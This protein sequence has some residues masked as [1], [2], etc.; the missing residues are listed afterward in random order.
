MLLGHGTLGD[1]PAGKCSAISCGYIGFWTGYSLSYGAHR[2]NPG[3][4]ARGAVPCAG[5]PRP[6]G[7]LWNADGNLLP[8]YLFI[9]SGVLAAGGGFA[10]RFLESIPRAG[11]S[12]DSVHRMVGLFRVYRLS[13]DRGCRGALLYGFC[14]PPG[15]PVHCDG[16]C[17]GL[18]DGIPASGAH[19]G[20]GDD[21]ERCFVL[22]GGSVFQR[23][24]ASLARSYEYSSF[25][26]RSAGFARKRCAGQQ[27]RRRASSS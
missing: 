17:R 5:E 26:C 6:A 10:A 14:L 20:L 8:E 27:R 25:S 11:Q 24:C 1:C 22:A 16:G 15:L 2:G 3:R 7:W 18:G 12:H 23:M 9:P 21:P 19:C 4:P 13:K